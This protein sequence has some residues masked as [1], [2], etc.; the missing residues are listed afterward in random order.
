MFVVTTSVIVHSQGV[1]RMKRQTRN[2]GGTRRRAGPR[3]L[4]AEAGF[5]RHVDAGRPGRRGGGAAR[6]AA[7]AVAAAVAGGGPMTV[8]QTATELTVERPGPTT[9]RRRRTYK[10]DGIRDR[11]CRPWR[12]ATVEGRPR[13]GT[14]PSSS[15]PPRPT[16]ASRPQTWSLAG[17]KLT[18]ER[19]GGRGPSDD[20]LQEDHLVRIS[21]QLTASSRQLRN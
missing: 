19:T 21:F 15:S 8:K 6:R 1:R 12:Q 20:G 5:L 14:A 9:A 4:R 17:G 7:A 18:I 11:R 13:S 2:D 10:L 16:A 3:R